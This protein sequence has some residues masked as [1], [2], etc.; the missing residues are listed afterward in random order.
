MVMTVRSISQ[1]LK[2]LRAHITDERVGIDAI[3]EGLHERGF[4]IF[5]L[6]CA[7]PMALPLP[8][9]PG[10]N[11]ILALPIALLTAQ[12]SIGRHTIWMPDNLKKK[13][14]SRD[15]FHGFLDKAIPFLE[16]L[17]IIIKPRLSFMT[18]G[19]FS[20]IIG[21]LGLV[22]A[23]TTMIPLPLTNT[24]P[25]IGISIMAIGVLSRDGL[26][27]LAGALIGMGWVILLAWAVVFLGTEGI[28]I[29]KDTIKSVL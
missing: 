17:E 25:C 6:I 7:L 3:L 28:D 20:N 5:L 26:A 13:T 15:K 9:P 11:V 8:V 10:I 1:T 24:V 27:V 23:L 19:V 2:D 21:V 29:I 12:Q 14:I 18:Q 4:G 16:T 22:M